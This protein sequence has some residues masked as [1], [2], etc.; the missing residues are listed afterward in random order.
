MDRNERITPEIRIKLVSLA[1]KMAEMGMQTRGW[2]WIL[3]FFSRLI[4]VMLL[5]FLLAVFL[6]LEQ[7]HVFKN[8]KDVL[9][10]SIIVLF[11]SLT[12]FVVYRLNAPEYLVPVTIGSMLMAT[13]FDSKIGYAGAAVLSIMVGAL[14]GNSYG[15][16]L[17]SF[18][19]GVVAV[20]IISRVRKRSQLISFIFYLMISYIGMITI[21]GVIQS[22]PFR[23][24][25][26]QWR[27]GV[28]N[29][30]FSP[31][32]T[33]GFLIP[34]IETVFD[35]T[36]DFTLL[37]LSNLNHPLLK[38]LSVQAPG[39][40][41]HSILVGNL[42]EAAA[43][44]LNA[45]SLLARVGSYYH[46][47]GK[48]EKAEYFV[49]NQ[50]GNQNA[51]AKLT[52]RMSALILG[53][54]VKKGL[55]FADQYKVPLAVKDI[56]VQHQGTQVMSFFYE[57]AKAKDGSEE[58]N[59][60]DYRYPGP[61][62][63]SKEAAIVMLADAVEAASRAMKEPNHSRLKGLIEE[64]VDERFQAGEL[65]ESPLTLRDLERIKASFLTILAG[66]FHARVEYP[67]KEDQK[68]PE[69]GQKTDVKETETEG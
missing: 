17:V 14:W 58:V 44:A 2:G 59:E 23:E 69:N 55:D 46:D 39:T 33:Y 67:E 20:V 50:I 62:P 26:S 12:A 47:V 22:L 18:F 63:Q 38:R 35:K 7:P 43:Q 21:M 61:K 60:N 36:T 8:T 10:I 37:E 19:C 41:H 6:K 28:I 4:F 27:W 5:L 11:I 9:L 1:S 56:V 16:M 25:L 48:I 34:F 66:T 24:I 40:Y 51:H 65:D 31:I 49:E 45:N 54:H 29:G 57:K 68:K 53:N 64:L 13:V 52:P 42:A 15:L 30:I 3:Y 32:I